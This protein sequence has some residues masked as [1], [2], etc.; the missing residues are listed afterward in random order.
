MPAKTTIILLLLTCLPRNGAPIR[1][2]E[3]TDWPQIHGARR[4]G[5]YRGPAL[6]DSLPAG[7]PAIPWKKKVGAGFAGPVV[8]AG[9][10]V[11]FHRQDGK[12]ILDCLD[13]A[14]GKSLWTSSYLAGYRDRFGFDEGPRAVPT[15]DDGRV[16]TN[17]AAGILSC[18]DLESGKKIWRLD[19]HASFKPRESFFG[20]ACA[21]L[22]SSGKV[23]VQVGGTT[24]I[25][26]GGKSSGIVAFDS[27]TGKPL[28]G[29]TSDEAGYSSPVIGKLGGKNRLVCLTR[30]GIVI[31]DPG[32][33][34]ILY[35][36]RWRARI[37][38]SV[39]AATPVINGDL[40]FFSSSYQ[41]GAIC[42][43]A[44]DKG[45]HELWS[46]DRILSNHYST[47]I[48]DS[49]YLYG[50]DGR[51]EYGTQLRCVSL[52]SGKI[53]WSE[54]RPGKNKFGSGTL[55]LAGEK[56]LVMA[57]SGELILASVSHKGYKRLDS[58]EILTS[59]ARAYPALAGGF[60]YARSTDELVCVDLRK[61]PKKKAG[62]K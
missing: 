40:I 48:Q 43:K 20:T 24:G 31:L 25:G 59:T 21:P 46:G 57:D 5:L 44:D 47:C 12:E 35:E 30:T 28:W 32:T 11:L 1:A 27:A 7:G 62:E 54:A 58:A 55:I 50:F 4:D 53:S 60:F 26:T 52:S 34:D 13:A 38:A 22:V 42:L 8:S 39:N 56:L 33:G 16:Y 18:T 10:L 6:M 61:S 19:T 23:F 15:I 3:A 29:A 49:G 36:K 45:Y 14:T 9:K 17:G 2:D 41:T 37:G 51:Q